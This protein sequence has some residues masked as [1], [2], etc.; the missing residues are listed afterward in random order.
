MSNKAAEVAR[1]PSATHIRQMR[2]YWGR[3]WLFFAQNANANAERKK[4]AH[5][6]LIYDSHLG[7]ATLFVA[8]FLPHR[9]ELIAVVG[10]QK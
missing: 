10:A 5:R 7:V 1:L 8:P 4:R 2:G 9:K 6:F 3:A